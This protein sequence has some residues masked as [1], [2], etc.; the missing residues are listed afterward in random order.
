MLL[1]AFLVLTSTQLGN[2]DQKYQS[3]DA[4][5]EP[6]QLSPFMHSSPQAFQIA[7]YQG[8]VWSRQ[9]TLQITKHHVASMVHLLLSVCFPKKG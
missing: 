2:W 9:Q 4:V 6:L 8:K 1:P 3:V 5:C 7:S